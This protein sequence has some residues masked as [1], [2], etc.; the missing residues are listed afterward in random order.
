MASDV[1]GD[2]LPRNSPNFHSDSGSLQLSLRVIDLA[3][4]AAGFLLPGFNTSLAAA[5]IARY[6]AFHDPS[7][8]LSA[9]TKVKEVSRFRPA[10]EAN[11]GSLCEPTRC[12]IMA[13]DQ[14]QTAQQG[15]GTQNTPDG[16]EN[17]AHRSSEPG[18]RGGQMAGGQS[19]MDRQ[20]ESQRG[21]QG[22]SGSHQG[23]Q[24]GAGGAVHQGGTGG[25][26]TGPKSDNDQSNIDESSQA[27]QDEDSGMTED[28]R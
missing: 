26:A 14:D 12:E 6:V 17:D 19:D 4:L 15:G 11:T 24:Q 18:Q 20:R 22:S 23:D 5:F 2:P 7:R 16:F 27:V 21:D 10:S 25:H 3:R 1:S 8:P 13:N 9:N 28:N